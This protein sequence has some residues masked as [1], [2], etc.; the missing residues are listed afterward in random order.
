MRAEIR[1][2]MT[3]DE[4]VNLSPVTRGST[5]KTRQKNAIEETPQVILY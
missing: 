3:P 4:Y 5:L 2:L 1:P